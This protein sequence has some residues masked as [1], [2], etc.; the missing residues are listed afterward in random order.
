[1]KNFKFIT[2]PV[3]WTVIA[4]LYPLTVF[5]INESALVGN[6]PTKWCINMS[7]ETDPPADRQIDKQVLF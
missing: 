2:E 5:S 7:C 1:M 3:G 4:I 6:S